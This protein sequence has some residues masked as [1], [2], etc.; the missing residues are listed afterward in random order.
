MKKK[1]EIRGTRSVFV[2]AE[3]ILD[4][5]DDEYVP[6]LADVENELPWLEWEEGD[7][8]PDK[9]VDVFCILDM[10]EVEEEDE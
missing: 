6:E 4:V 1:F 10:G 8:W 3:I 5:P 7:D 9:Y 2:T